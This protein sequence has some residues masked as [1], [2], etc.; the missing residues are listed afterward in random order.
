MNP[1][2]AGNEVISVMSREQDLPSVRSGKQDILLLDI[3]MA[4]KASPSFA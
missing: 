1:A 3:L 2:P 4:P